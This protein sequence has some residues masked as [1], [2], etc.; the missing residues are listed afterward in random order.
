VAEHGGRTALVEPPLQV[1]P[2]TR[3]G[4]IR[5]GRDAAGQGRWVGTGAVAMFLHGWSSARR[6]RM[7][8]PDR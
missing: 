7:A 5:A 4:A 1:A 3:R 8:H 2:P 6:T